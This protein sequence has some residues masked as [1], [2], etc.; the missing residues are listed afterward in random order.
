MK[1][2]MHPDLNSH[3]SESSPRFCKPVNHFLQPAL[4]RFSKKRPTIGLV[5]VHNEFEVIGFAN[6]LLY[7]FSGKYTVHHL[8]NVGLF[9]ASKIYAASRFIFVP[10][11]TL[12]KMYMKV[13][14]FKSG[15]KSLQRKFY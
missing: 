7:K 3:A 12:H 5:I 15:C 10:K 9:T 6:H 8:K 13:K 1:S 4:L 14:C 2:N 11:Y